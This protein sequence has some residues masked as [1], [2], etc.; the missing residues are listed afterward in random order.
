MESIMKNIREVS[1]PVRE[2]M[3]TTVL[4]FLTVKASKRVLLMRKGRSRFFK[5][6]GAMQYRY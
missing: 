2:I 1:Q 6:R 3:L 4:T 5:D